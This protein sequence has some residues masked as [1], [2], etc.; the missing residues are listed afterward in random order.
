MRES[1]LPFAYTATQVKFAVIFYEVA[2]TM[3]EHFL[4]YLALS[5]FCVHEMDAVRCREWRIFP[6]LSLANDRWGK[7]IFI[8]AH[9]PL[10]FILWLQLATA[11]HSFITGMN[12]FFMIHTLM[13]LLYLRHK[14][15]NLRMAYPG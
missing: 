1:G 2:Y 14:K 6:L 11:G 12:I 4:F 10:F 15:M 13:H 3:P 5:F 7:S 9:I 8:L